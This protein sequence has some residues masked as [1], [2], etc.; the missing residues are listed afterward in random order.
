MEGTIAVT[1]TWQGDELFG[2]EVGAH[3]P[4]LDGTSGQG[5]S[6]MQYLATGITG[7]MAIDIAH[8]LG[9]MRTPAQS[10]RVHL[11]TE[12]VAEPPRRFTALRFHVEAVGDVPQ[13]NLDRAIALSR[14]KYCSAM[15]S[16]RPDIE[17]T[18]DTE[19]RPA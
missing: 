14:D 17:V 11:N 9:R 18:V 2:V 16:L 6:P 10:L 3:R 5:P 19:I 7:C 8:I 1:M 13:A 12:R 4:V 15:H